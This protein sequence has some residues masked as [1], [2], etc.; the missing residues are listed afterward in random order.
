METESQVTDPKTNNGTI[1]ARTWTRI[2]M[3]ELDDHVAFPL[4]S[5]LHVTE[6]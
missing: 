1:S 4:S 2:K 6:V 3:N 5:V